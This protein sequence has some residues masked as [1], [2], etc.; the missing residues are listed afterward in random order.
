M[1]KRITNSEIEKARR[2]NR[3]LFILT[4][5]MLLVVI[6]GLVFYVLYDKHLIS[7]G[8]V[9]SVDEESIIS[10]NEIRFDVKNDNREALRLY[11]IV[12]VSNN[13]CNDYI[14]SKNIKVKDLSNDCKFE[15]ASNIYNRYLIDEDNSKFV[16]EEDVI[17][18]YESLFGEGTYKSEEIIPYIDNSTLYYSEINKKYFLRDEIIDMDTNMNNHEEILSIKKDNN[19]L[20]INSAIMYYDSINKVICK[21]YDCEEIVEKIGEEPNSDYY[22][23][24]IKHNKNKLYN[25]HYKFRLDKN[26]FYKYIGFERT[27]K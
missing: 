14:K 3:F 22:S 1:K 8:D 25:Y 13:D 12:R 27:I 26:G 4:V 2:S 9:K 20:Y 15:I 11:N 18:A 17:Y 5:L 19:Y 7:F 24:Y 16:L 10:K 6:G 21:D 23:L